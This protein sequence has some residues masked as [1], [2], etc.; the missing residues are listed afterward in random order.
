MKDKQYADMTTIMQFGRIFADQIL[1][2]MKHAGLL[3]QGFHF[4]IRVEKGY[5]NDEA[6]QRV[7][8][9][10]SL[11]EVSHEEWQ[12]SAMAQFGYGEGREWSVYHDPKA[13][14]GSLPTEVYFKQR[15]EFRSRAEAS[16]KAADKPLPPDGLWISRYDYDDPVGGGR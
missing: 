1:L 3:E 14:A 15:S 11:N 2:C 6:F 13:E 8:L 16:R 5:G 4:S 12:E 9:E 10:K 7:E